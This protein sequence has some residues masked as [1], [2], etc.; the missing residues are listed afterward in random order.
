MNKHRRHLPV[1]LFL[2][3]GIVLTLGIYACVSSKNQGIQII[4]AFT[5]GV[6]RP[7]PSTSPANLTQSALQTAEAT[8]LPSALPTMIITDTHGQ[9]L[10][11]TQTQQA[12]QPRQPGNTSTA[13]S[14]PVSTRTATQA[15]QPTR[16]RTATQ[17]NQPTRTR[18]AT[19]A[20]QPTATPTPTTIPSQTPPTGWAGEWIVRWQLDNQS[21]ADGLLTVDVQDTD[22]T[23]SAV[24]AGI[25]YTFTGRIIFDGKTA[26]GN[27]TAAANS[28]NFIW[29]DVASGQFGGSRDLLFGF[30]GSR[31]GF[32][33]P[34]PC[35]IE[36]LS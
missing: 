6:N 18:T 22:F 19:Q 4:N 9:A 28:G 23:A 7:Q 27:W 5:P 26:I 25:Q 15:N 1:L 30:C 21:Y 31:A 17:A 3:V 20:N 10:I 35:Y 13:A 32:E 33:A 12:T 16:T 8:Q 36:P 11:A 2:A 29:E 14:D 24:I 34:E